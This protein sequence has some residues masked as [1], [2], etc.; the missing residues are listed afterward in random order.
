MAAVTWSFEWG[1]RIH[2]KVHSYGSWQIS[3]PHWLLV[4]D[5]LLSATLPPYGSR[6]LDQMIQEGET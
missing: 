3:V 6:L 4:R 5:F 1:W 2:F